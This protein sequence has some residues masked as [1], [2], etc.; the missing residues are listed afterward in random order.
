MWGPG[1]HALQTGRI[2]SSLN[3]QIAAALASIPGCCVVKPE[4]ESSSCLRICWES[5]AVQSS[6][7]FFASLYHFET[8]SVENFHSCIWFKNWELRWLAMTWVLVMGI[9]C[10]CKIV[11]Y[12]TSQ[13]SN[14]DILGNINKPVDFMYC[15]IIWAHRNKNAF[16]YC[17]WIKTVEFLYVEGERGISRVCG[18]HKWESIGS[19]CS[20]SFCQKHTFQ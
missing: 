15:E 12:S 1:L 5:Q 2:V 17:M 20:V 13:R 3:T 10:F 19:L 7:L 16:S 6:P 8:Y 9:F 18:G 14:A 4:V 11:Y